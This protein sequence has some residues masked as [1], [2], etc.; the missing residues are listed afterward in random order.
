MPDTREPRSVVEAAEQAAAMGD[1]ALA[2][3]HLRDAVLLQEAGF[4]S[5]H[6]D[7]ANTL[8]NLGVVCEMADKPEEAEQCYRRAHAIATAALAPDHP[9]V[10]TSRKN[11]EDFCRARRIPV[12][13]PAPLKAIAQDPRSAD[14]PAERQ[15]REQAAPVPVRNSPH[16]F[17]T[18][19]LGASALV[20]AIVL[21]AARPWFD[22]KGDP[23][24]PPVSATE[25]PPPSAAPTPEPRRVEPPRA[26]KET[27]ARSSAPAVRGRRATPAPPAVV[28]AR[29]CRNIS[30]GAR[31]WRCDA[32]GSVVNP[33]SLFFYT[34]LRA[35]RNTTVLHRW[36][37]GDRLQQA[38][39]LRVRANP[40]TG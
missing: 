39:E 33:G 34:R 10:A 23:G 32:A 20:V 19:A 26:A 28:N 13:V 36:Y 4:G 5:L 14:Q 1:Y 2:E 21:F 40:G 16:P 3:R 8:N 38:G 25:L 11:L 15:V 29:L 22:S 9:F 37:R 27:T 7:L 31:D 35:A 30:T 17:A 18:G 12:D 6:P 24:S